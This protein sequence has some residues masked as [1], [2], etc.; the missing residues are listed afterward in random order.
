MTMQET[1]IKL[2]YD[3]DCRDA[4]IAHCLD[5]GFQYRGTVTEEDLYYTPAHRDFLK[6]KR[7]LRLR[8]VHG[9]DGRT[10]TRIT[11]KGPNRTEGLQDR[12]ELETDVEDGDIL[13]EIFRQLDFQ[14]LAIVRKKRAYYQK[15]RFS[16][17]IDRVDGLGDFF[18]A[19]IL[20]EEQAAGILEQFLRTLPFSSFQTEP[21]TYL[22]L[23]LRETHG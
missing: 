14:P 21:L 16:V 5:Q 18:E 11:Y 8:L 19:E 6:E 23:L 3:S 12:E 13:K 10:R 17:C 9:E 22:E 4:L 2:R 1:E 7:A 20:G 15:D